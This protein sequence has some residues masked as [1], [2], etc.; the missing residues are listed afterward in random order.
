MLLLC[1]L[2]IISS[3]WKWVLHNP[4]TLG[5]QEYTAPVCLH[6]TVAH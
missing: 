4:D 6:S 1:E 5:M 2:A 3:W